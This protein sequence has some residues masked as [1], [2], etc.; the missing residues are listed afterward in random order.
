MYPLPAATDPQQRWLR[1]VAL[2]GQGFYSGARAELARLQREVTAGPLASFAASTEASLLRQLGWHRAAAA[3]DGRAFALAREVQARGV[4]AQGVEAQG[5]QAQGVQRGARTTVTAAQCDALTGLAA[6]ALGCGR[7]DLSRRLLAQCA[8]RLPS[9][10]VGDTVLWRQRIRLHWVRAEVA[11]A[12]GDFATAQA[13][14]A[15]ASALADR[16]RS[17][18]HQVKSDLLRAASATGNADL[19]QARALAVDVSERC[20]DH[21]LVPLRWAAAM[22]ANGIGAAVD[23]D[24]VR[25]ECAEIVM[26]RGGHFAAFRN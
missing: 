17:V 5:V 24:R 19:G 23:A 18:R 15:Q 22:L 13:H 12:S 8:D 2:G 7:L 4:Q 6:D 1:A 26:R 21:G 3:Y 16:S 10:D 11:L 14:A 9:S 20:A 25:D